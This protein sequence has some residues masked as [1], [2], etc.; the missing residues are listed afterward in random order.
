MEREL[1][2][3]V[4]RVTELAAL[5]SA[6]WI[7][8][9]DKTSADDAAT[10]AMR[11][12]FD[13]VSMRGTVV[14]G[15][16]EM[17]EAPMLYI[18]EPLGNGDGPE[19]DVAVDPLEGTN[20]VA[21]GLNN[22]LAVVAIANKGQ[23]LHAPDMYMQK[24]AVGPALAGKLHLLDPVEVTLAKAADVLG[25]PLSDLN[26]M[27]LDRER[28]AP[29]IGTMRRLGARIS[30]L[31][32]GDVAGAIAPAFPE[33]GI[34]LY[35]GSGGAPEGVLAAAALKALGGEIQGRLLPENPEQYERAVA[36][37]LADPD[38]VLAME[39]LV[40][41][42]DVIFAATGVTHGEFLEGVRYLPNQRAETHS[43]VMR[44]KTGTVRFIKTI[45]YL[46]N[47]T[48]RREESA[49]LTG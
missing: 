21:R 10:T 8:R 13:S 14:I 24:L 36:M 15:E 23:L 30:L 43:I 6:P 31:S 2:L 37:G 48:V 1:A 7:G 38:R 49:S 39:D 35:L 12:M 33:T 3:E 40:G 41:T 19:V 28:H 26:V 16:G 29:I 34:D 46:P 11:T 44:A 4:V 5:E 27:I 45:H 22:A 18:G 25:K 42:D 47:K 17:D 9:G 20:L 32:D